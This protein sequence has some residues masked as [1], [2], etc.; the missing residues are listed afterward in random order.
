MKAAC[1]GEPECL[2]AGMNRT[3][4]LDFL[5][6]RIFPFKDH[7]KQLRALFSGGPL[8]DVVNHTRLGTEGTGQCHPASVTGEESK[9]KPS[10]TTPRNWSQSPGLVLVSVVLWGRTGPGMYTGVSHCHRVK[11]IQGTV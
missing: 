1:K 5:D 11:H 8:V 3:H 2:G 4:V 6:E 9:P 10:H 7:E